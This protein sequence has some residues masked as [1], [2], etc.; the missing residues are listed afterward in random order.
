MKE[1]SLVR[2]EIVLNRIINP[3]IMADDSKG[4]IVLRIDQGSIPEI[5]D[6]IDQL[7]KRFRQLQRTTILSEDLTPP[8]FAILRMLWM[9]DAQ[10]FK[11]L[12]SACYFHSQP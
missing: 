6:L 1:A 11:D 8:Q 7:S 9:K 10:P 2:M 5:A 4:Q 12:A 3:N